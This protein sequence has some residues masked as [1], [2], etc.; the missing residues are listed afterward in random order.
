MNRQQMVGKGRLYFLF[1]LF[2]ILI[3]VIAARLFYIQIEKHDYYSQ[4]AEKQ[5]L[6]KTVLQAKRGKIFF[7]DEFN[8]LA[9]NQ[10]MEKIAVAPKEVEDTQKLAEELSLVIKMDKKEILAKISDKSDPWIEIGEI[11]IEKAKPLYDIK[12]LHFQSD[13]KRY[14]PQEEVAAHVIGFLNKEKVGQ[15]GVEEYYNKELKG[16]DGF[17]RGIVDAKGRKILSPF[18]KIQDP[19]DGDD[20]VLT[21]DFNIQLFIE[22]KLK[23]MVKKYGAKGGTI[24]VSRPKTG[25][26]LGIASLSSFSKIQNFNPNEYNLVKKEEMDVFKNPAISIPFESGSIFKPVTMAGAL[27][28]NVITPQT[29]YIDKGEVKIGRYIIKN[30]DLK[31]HGKKTMTE[32]LEFSLNTGAV[33]AQQKL[34]GAKFTEYVQKFG[35]G[36]KTN[37]DLAG[38]V[39]GNI[40]NILEPLSREKLIEYA[41]ASF[42]QGISITPIQIIQAFSA[43][44][45]QGQMVKPYIVKKVIHPDETFEET[46]P[47]VI[48]QVISSETALRLTA[49]MVSAVKNGYG[50][51]AGLEGY[52][53][54]GKTGTA[55]VPWAYFGIQKNGYSDKTI[56]SFINFAPAF[57]PEFVLFLKMEGQTKGPRF[58]ADSLAPI[59]KEINQYLFT[60][61]GIPPE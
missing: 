42:G 35:F 39:T 46:K 31:A 17:W 60:Y 58:S 14:Y 37:I 27:E 36:Q 26:I 30:S 13:F 21:L 61:F 6:S 28:E 7:S 29:T 15:Y 57:N 48:S 9:A 33:F 32:V 22:D 40:K 54:A 47:A 45:N 10:G 20:L 34:G 41:N 8:L 16:L 53:I 19:V 59:A 25:E 56:Q 50:K 12:G 1:F 11:P 5:H 51:K 23:E 55:Q 52:L 18:N 3:A 4:L 44:A 43:I 49:M 24:I 38:E 2:F